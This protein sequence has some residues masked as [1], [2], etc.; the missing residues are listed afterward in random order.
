MKIYKYELQVE[1]QQSIEMPK[2]AQIIS[3]SSQFGIPC[4]WAIVDENAKKESRIFHTYGTGQTFYPKGAT[5]V[6]TYFLNGGA[7]VYHVFD[8]Q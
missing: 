1:D 3:I 5:F 6:G 8:I 2:G 4:I 7:I